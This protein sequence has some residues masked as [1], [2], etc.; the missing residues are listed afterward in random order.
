[1]WRGLNKYHQV[2][3]YSK[4]IRMEKKRI[5]LVSRTFYPTI[6]PRS[7]R[8]TELVKE[9][10][11][12]G[13]SVTLITVKNDQYHIPFEQKWGVVIKDFGPLRFP[14]VKPS[15]NHRLMNRI[16]WKIQRIFQLLFE[17]PDIEIMPRLKKTL[18]NEHGYDLLISIAVPH[19]VHWGVA[20]ARR[21]KNQIA[22]IWA[23]DCGDPY[24]GFD[25][26]RIRKPFYFKYLEKMFCRKANYITVPFEGAK[27]AYYAE[28]RNKIK[29]IPQGF[30]FDKVDQDVKSYCSNGTPK[31]AYAG[32]LLGGGRNPNELLNYLVNLD[33]DFKFVIY[34]QN[35]R[36]LLPYL[37][38][39]KSRIE[40]R[41]YIPR[42]QLLN[43]LSSMDFLVNL[44]NQ[45]TNQLPSKII[46]YYL[47]GRPILSVPSSGMNTETINRFLDGDYSDRL[48][49]NNIDKYRIKNVCSQFLNLC[50][51][52]A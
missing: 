50:G 6:S 35:K 10:A 3:G 26:D 11:R 12:Q 47:T 9:F 41:D 1:M 17:Y 49:V 43:T 51:K 39:A 2:G 22:K 34:T 29:V 27:E 20:W 16:A 13:H 24:M 44:E 38:K 52:I 14:S 8:T 28:F 42:D 25:I 45:T 30:S 31:L 33:R 19:P 48:I 4:I 15:E 21:E 32:N 37:E 7:F 5:L 23:A 36:P 18:A 46:D 40:I